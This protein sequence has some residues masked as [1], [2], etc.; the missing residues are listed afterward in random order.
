MIIGEGDARHAV[1]K[2]IRPFRDLFVGIFFIGIGTQLPVGIA[3]TSRAAVLAWLGILFLGKALIFLAVA[4][5]FGEPLP[6]SLRT[7]IILAH[8]GEFSLMLLSVSM[9]SGL[10]HA[11]FGGP[12]FIAIGISMMCG[13]VLVRWAGRDT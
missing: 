8:G 6:A 9:A 1:E 4:R 11:T 5:W 3:A 12:L 10:L 13:S 7:G 2:A